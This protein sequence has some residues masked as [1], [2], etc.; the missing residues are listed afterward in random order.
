MAQAMATPEPCASL[1]VSV[2][3][4]LLFRGAEDI[5]VWDTGEGKAPSTPKLLAPG[6]KAV[7]D[8]QHRRVTPSSQQEQGSQG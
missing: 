2:P 8:L 1:E 5:P 6:K 4:A 7:S 3:P